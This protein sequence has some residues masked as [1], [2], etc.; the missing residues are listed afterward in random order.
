M[1]QV[2]VYQIQIILN[3]TILIIVITSSTS[4]HQE[5]IKLKVNTFLIINEIFAVYKHFLTII[6]LN[7]IDERGTLQWRNLTN[8]IR[9]KKKFT[10][11]FMNT[12]MYCT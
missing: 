1:Y 6:S 2:I 3:S 8:T 10:Q 5:M 4:K 12:K 11:Q 9:D 7:W